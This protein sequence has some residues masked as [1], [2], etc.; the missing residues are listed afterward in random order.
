M[1]S[2][3]P[4]NLGSGSSLPGSVEYSYRVERTKV[5]LDDA[6]T[7]PT[8]IA[9]KFPVPNPAGSISGGL[10]TTATGL[11]F[12]DGTNTATLTTTLPA[13][14]EDLLVG[15]QL[16]P[17]GSSMG[18]YLPESPWNANAQLS[19]SILKKSYN[20]QSGIFSVYGSGVTISGID[21]VVTKASVNSGVRSATGGYVDVEDGDV[22]LVA[23]DIVD[24]IGT[25]NKVITL[26]LKQNAAP[27]PTTTVGNIT[28]DR[29][30]LCGYHVASG[31]E[32]IRITV[33]SVSTVDNLPVSFRHLTVKKI[34]GK[35]NNLVAFG[36][37]IC[38]RAR[39]GSV[40]ISRSFVDLFCL[41]N[42]IPYTNLGVFGETLTQIAARFDTGAFT[43]STVL[44]EGGVNDIHAASADPT[45]TM[46]LKMQ[47][48]ITKALA[49][50]PE[51]W[52]ATVPY[53]GPE[54]M[55]ALK[56]GWRSAYNDWLK[57]V[58]GIRIIDLDVPLTDGNGN[59]IA[60]YY[61]VTD[62]T[63]PNTLGHEAVYTYMESLG[64]R[65]RG[66][67]L[68]VI[69]TAPFDGTIPAWGS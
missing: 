55:P 34:S 64:L 56:N 60:E 22:I 15:V 65:H 32:P 67:Y 45:A 46:I 25:A 69:S 5:G 29:T 1:A 37:S 41:S 9:I 23:V 3:S 38:L 52:V 7:R 63:H 16:D 2:F 53:T 33:S 48:M 14:G 42:R 62:L 50:A 27:Y 17:D 28:S 30:L 66:D 68:P 21:T 13:A 40:H 8:T 51:V 44:L 57:T 35:R 19:D 43:P 54:Y 18:L 59:Q 12:T 24:P 31:V 26:E 61:E 47:E 4:V 20:L 39:L 49:L 6:I 10:S 11:E 58:P 36:D